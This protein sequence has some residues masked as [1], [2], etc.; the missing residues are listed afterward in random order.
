METSKDI[1]L[2][3]DGYAGPQYRVLRTAI[4]T[5]SRVTRVSQE[6]DYSTGVRV[7]IPYRRL[8]GP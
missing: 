6:V 3:V 8:F 4:S 2:A 7:R 1:R 5:S